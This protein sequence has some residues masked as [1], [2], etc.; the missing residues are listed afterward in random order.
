MKKTGCSNPSATASSTSVVSP[1]GS[2]VVDSGATVVMVDPDA[3]VVVVVAEPSGS[4][5]VVVSGPAVD[6][7]AGAEDGTVLG[8]DS[9]V[10]AAATSTTAIGM[11]I[12]SRMSVGLDN[13]GSLGCLVGLAGDAATLRLVDTRQQVDAEDEEDNQAQDGRA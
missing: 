3:T 6:V 7:V 9:E 2:V 11:M 1:I 12:R 5:V 13:S 10:Q 8:A 4:V